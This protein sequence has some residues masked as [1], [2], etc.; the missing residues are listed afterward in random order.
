MSKTAIS[1]KQLRKKKYKQKKKQ[2]KKL[3]R[4]GL[5]PQEI[6]KKMEE[7]ERNEKK[8]KNLKK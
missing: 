5:S 8:I 2:I 4:M 7:I 3:E 6:G 1:G